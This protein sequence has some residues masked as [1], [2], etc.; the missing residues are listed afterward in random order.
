MQ[1]FADLERHADGFE[2]DPGIKTLREARALAEKPQGLHG[3][4]IEELEVARLLVEL[5]LASR[6]KMR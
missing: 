1:P 2:A 5:G 6:A 4:A 3:L